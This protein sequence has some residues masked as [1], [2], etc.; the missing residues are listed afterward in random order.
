M[1]CDIH[2]H[3]IDYKNK[4]LVDVSDKDIDE[5][6]KMGQLAFSAG[7][8]PKYM[9]NNIDA[10]LLKIKEMAQKGMLTAIGECGLDKFSEWDIATQEKCLLEQFIIAKEYGLPVIIH[11]V[12]LYS[13][14]LR[15]IKF[16]KFSNPVI[17]HCYNGNPDTTKQLLNY[18]NIMYSYSEINIEPNCG[19][20]KS[21]GYI[22]LN[23]IL[24]ESDVKKDTNFSKIIYN[25][26][27]VKKTGYHEL[28]DQVE[29]NFDSIICRHK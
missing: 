7:I 15:I 27:D 28:I 5:I 18:D 3:S 13:Q 19:G 29:K 1:F 9:E 22:P 10:K 6:Q 11:C 26:S 14:I 25:I 23:R 17:F 20:Y 24:T 21:L 2:T 8:H 16:T 4:S 12:R